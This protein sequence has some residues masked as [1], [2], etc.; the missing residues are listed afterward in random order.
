MVQASGVF[1]SLQ[2]TRYDDMYAFG[3]RGVLCPLQWL[4]PAGTGVPAVLINH[5]RMVGL[6]AAQ[7]WNNGQLRTSSARWDTYLVCL[8]QGSLGCGARQHTKLP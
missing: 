3:A 2:Q 7:T 4:D 8:H 6:A 1:G 5:W